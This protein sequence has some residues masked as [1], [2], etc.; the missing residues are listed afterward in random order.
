MKKNFAAKPQVMDVVTGLDMTSEINPL[1]IN[2]DMI[3]KPS[4]NF[5]SASSTKT[6]LNAVGRQGFFEG[7]GIDDVT[8]L[9]NTGLGLWGASEQNKADI[10][11]AEKARQIAEQQA[12]QEEFRLEQE[13]IRL[14]QIGQANI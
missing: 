3:F 6:Y 11:E 5:V 4:N 1:I 2:S 13:R 12:Q 7:F 14:E 8:S 10:A 9:I